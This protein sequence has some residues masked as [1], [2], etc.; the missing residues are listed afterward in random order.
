METFS[1]LLGWL[2]FA[3]AMLAT[4]TGG[5]LLA[6][7]VQVASGAGWYG[8]RP[9]PGGV[10]RRADE[11]EAR[12]RARYRPGARAAMV[13]AQPSAVVGP[14]AEIDPGEI[15]PAPEPLAA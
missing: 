7:V 13:P 10:T 6:A 8:G 2:T 14:R 5:C 4:V 1:G 3:A 15:A 12:L 9:L 11:V